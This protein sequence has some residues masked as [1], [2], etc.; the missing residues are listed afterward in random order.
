MKCKLAVVA[1]VPV[2][3]LGMVGCSSSEP[4][5][6]EPAPAIQDDGPDCDDEDASHWEEPDCGYYD[7]GGYW[8]WHSYV[9]P[10]TRARAKGVPPK[11]IHKVHPS[12]GAY[13]SKATP[14]VKPAPVTKSTPQK[15]SMWDK[16]TGKGKSACGFM[17]KPGVGGGS[18]SSGGSSYKGGG[19][20]S[21]YKGGSSSSSGKSWSWP[22]GSSN[23]GAAP[24]SKPGC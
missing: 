11:G 9:T 14:P 2:I 22:G 7:G 10:A 1:L 20:S 5:N 16:I 19:S 8:I 15:R 21:S 17:S 12:Q 6:Y 18:S 24:K 3:A 4:S 23:K 13:N